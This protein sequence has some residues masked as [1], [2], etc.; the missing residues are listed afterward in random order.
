MPRARSLEDTL[1]QLARARR[2]PRSADTLALLRSA[3]AGKSAHA[4]ARAAEIVAEAELEAALPD[5]V[6]AFER[7]LVQPVRSDPSCTAKTAIADAL[8]R[9]GAAEIGVYLKGIRH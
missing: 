7:L 9:M 1:E 6:T 4:T 5:L 3:L 8:Y 2:E